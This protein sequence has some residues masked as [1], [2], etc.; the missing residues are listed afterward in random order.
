M[1]TCPSV[2][3]LLFENTEEGYVDKNEDRAGCAAEKCG[4]LFY[5]R[6]SNCRY[7]DR[8]RILAD[9]FGP[10]R[11]CI[12]CTCL[13][14]QSGTAGPGICQYPT[15]RIGKQ[16][17]NVAYRRI[18]RRGTVCA[19]FYL[20][21]RYG[22]RPD[23]PDPFGGSVAAKCPCSTDLAAD[24]ARRFLAA[25][26]IGARFF[27]YGRKFIVGRKIL[28]NH[29]CVSRSACRLRLYGGGTFAGAV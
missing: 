27:H 15:S 21:L 20:D 17:R 10:K 25:L 26:V 18:A 24:D 3:L 28:P 23:H 4:T 1:Q 12:V 16:N 6:V 8:S 29:C 14:R 2:F 13:R 5:E 19:G 9:L 22:R 11:N 7:R